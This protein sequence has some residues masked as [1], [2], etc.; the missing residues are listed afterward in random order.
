LP[1]VGIVHNRVGLRDSNIVNR[2]LLQIR[3]ALERQGRIHVWQ[4]VSANAGFPSLWKKSVV[5]TCPL[6]IYYLQSREGLEF[7]ITK[8]YNNL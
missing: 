7:D 4:S 6:A 1:I 3:A 5:V 8:N 2:H